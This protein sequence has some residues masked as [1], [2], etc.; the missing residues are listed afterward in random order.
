MGDSQHLCER[1]EIVLPEA[2]ASLIRG[3]CVIY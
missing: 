3:F 2:F 1:Y